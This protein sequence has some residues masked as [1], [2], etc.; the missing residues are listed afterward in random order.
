MTID[1]LS[2]MVDGEVIS[3]GVVF[4]CGDAPPAPQDDT[5]VCLFLVLAHKFVWCIGIV[6]NS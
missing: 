3:L 4:H 6:V 2:V 5:V 1:L